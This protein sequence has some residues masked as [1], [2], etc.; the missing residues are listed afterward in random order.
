MYQMKFALFS[1]SDP[2]KHTD[3]P[4]GGNRFGSGSDNSIISHRCSEQI[5][6]LGGQDRLALQDFT[7]STD[8]TCLHGL[9]YHNCHCGRS[10]QVSKVIGN[11][12]GSLKP[13][14]IT[15]AITKTT[16]KS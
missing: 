10:L 7:F 14:Y 4:F 8:N 5:L 2:T 13:R 11:L 9:F 3:I 6:A 12:I 1:G 15:N 16:V